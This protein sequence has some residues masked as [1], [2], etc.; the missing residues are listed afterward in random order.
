MKDEWVLISKA[1]QETGYTV[2]A[3]RTKTKRNIWPQGTMWRYAP[4]HRIVV[5]LYAVR[6]WMAGDR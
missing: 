1:A 6:K 5:N 3:I 2:E 4:D